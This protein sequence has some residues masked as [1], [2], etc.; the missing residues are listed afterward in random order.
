MDEKIKEGFASQ[1]AAMLLE[2]GG[3][4][5]AT[6]EGPKAKGVA[7][8]TSIELSFDATRASYE[9]TLRMIGEQ[10]SSHIEGYEAQIAELESE[11]GEARIALQGAVTTESTLRADLENL[12]TYLAEAHEQRRKSEAVMLEAERIADDRSKE[13]DR[14]R[15]DL[16]RMTIENAKLQGYVDRVQERDVLTE[17]EEYQ[18]RRDADRVGPYDG[19]PTHQPERYRG[20]MQYTDAPLSPAWHLRRQQ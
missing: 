13:I 9:D 10:H 12:R 20:E 1:I 6:L 7:L 8:L 3:P 17:R 2:S 4:E 5:A 15:D 14:L 18:L 16:H 19:M 11:A